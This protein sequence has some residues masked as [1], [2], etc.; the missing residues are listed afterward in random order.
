V[1]D[2]GNVVSD[3]RGSLATVFTDPV[4]RLYGS[5]GVIGRTIVLHALP[6]D[7]GLGNNPASL[8]TGNSGARIACGVIGIAP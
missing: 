5:F 4:S 3:N 2:Y 1:G 6:D 7:L 8:T